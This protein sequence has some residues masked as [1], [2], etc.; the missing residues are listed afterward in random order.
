VDELEKGTSE[1]EVME[2]QEDTSLHVVSKARMR[3][4]KTA[5]VCGGR[6]VGY[7]GQII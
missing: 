5:R 7:H 3:S 2:F 6:I 1:A 4:R